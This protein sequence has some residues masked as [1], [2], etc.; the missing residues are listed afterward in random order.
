MPDAI[1]SPIKAIMPIKRCD[2]GTREGTHDEAQRCRCEQ[3]E[4]E[5]RD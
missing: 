1:M 4:Q 3:C 2:G 5:A